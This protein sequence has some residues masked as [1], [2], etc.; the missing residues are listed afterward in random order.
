MNYSSLKDRQ[1]RS[2]G[3]YAFSRITHE[4][5]GIKVRVICQI[6]AYIFLYS[7]I[8]SNMGS[9]I[10]SKKKE[11]KSDFFTLIFYISFN[12]QP[13]AIQFC[14]HIVN[15]HIVP[16]IFD[17]GLVYHFMLKNGKLLTFFLYSF[18]MKRF[19]FKLAI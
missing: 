13:S 2:R 7:L 3:G 11:I 19:M 1:H 15:I 14:I 5:Q 4:P 12:I 18:Y 16:Q 8:G 6:K 17:L 9:L 10:K